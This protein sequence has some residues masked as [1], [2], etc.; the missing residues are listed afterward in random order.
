MHH[1]SVRVSLLEM[2]EYRPDRLLDEVATHLGART[3]GELA[4]LLN[5]SPSTISKVRRKVTAI[6]AGHLLSI[7]EE[8]EISIKDLREMMGDKRKFFY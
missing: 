3:D 2:P 5:I 6:T 4:K 7:H 8:S 1:L